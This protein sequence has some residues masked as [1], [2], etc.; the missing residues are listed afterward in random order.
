MNLFF[1][2]VAIGMGGALGAVA[3]YALGLL[4]IRHRSGFPIMTLMINI[5]GALVIG[6]IAAWVG[7]H[8][9][10]DGRLVLF[11]KVGLCGGFTTFSSF[12][13]ETFG[14]VQAGSASVGLVYAVLSV[15]LCVLACAI[16]QFILR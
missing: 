1:D 15:I 8:A 13:L 5:V 10:L 6:L 11:L 12:A 16:P 3:R 7:K 2:F 14:L 4:G 9:K